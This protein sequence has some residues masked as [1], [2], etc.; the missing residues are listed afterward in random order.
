[1]AWSVVFLRRIL[2]VKSKRR[3]GDAFGS[4]Q[5]EKTREQI[6]QS[7]MLARRRLELADAQAKE[8]MESRTSL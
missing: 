5:A 7:K 3:T 4:V 2:D 1:M 8:M 6:R